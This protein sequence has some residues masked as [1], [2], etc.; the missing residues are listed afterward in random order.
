VDAALDEHNQQSVASLLHVS[1]Q[2]PCITALPLALIDCQAVY[3]S[4]ICPP[5][6]P[7]KLQLIGSPPASDLCHGP[8]LGPC[9]CTVLDGVCAL[10]LIGSPTQLQQAT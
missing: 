10:V 2:L 4:L 5:A 9:T 7:S 8:T 6:K 1:T 3:L